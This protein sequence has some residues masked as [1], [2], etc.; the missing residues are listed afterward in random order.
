MYSKVNNQISFNVTQVLLELA[1]VV[2]LRF[3]VLK[4]SM[5]QT[6]MVGFFHLVLYF[7]LYHYSCRESGNAIPFCVHG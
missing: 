6:P 2:N 7:S 1:V 3:F 5:V 4:G